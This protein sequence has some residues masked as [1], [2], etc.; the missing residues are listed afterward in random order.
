M[1]KILILEKC[2]DCGHCKIIHGSIRCDHDKFSLKSIPDTGKVLPDCHL[3]DSDAWKKEL[4]EWIEKEYF[5]INEEETLD[6]YVVIG[7]DALKQKIQEM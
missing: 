1:S 5:E 6:A 7:R 4:L 3:P 2:M